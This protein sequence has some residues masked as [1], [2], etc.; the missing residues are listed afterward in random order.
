MK[1]W[2]LYIVFCCAFAM[3]ACTIEN[4]ETDNIA[5]ETLDTHNYVLAVEEASNADITRF[6]SFELSE[7]AANTEP[8]DLLSENEIFTNADPSVS[9]GHQ[10]IGRYFFA[11]AKDKKGYSSTPGVYRLT[12]NRSNR[13]FI[14]ESLNLRKNS[15]FPSR[16][17]CI[18]N[19]DLG[20]YY[21]EGLAAHSI[22]IFNPYAMVT[23][24]VIDLQEAIQ[25]FRS[26][27][28]WVDESGNNRV[29]TGSMVIDEKEGKLYVSIVF[30]ETVGFNIIA[31]EDSDFYLAVIDIATKK[32]EKIISYPDTRTV[33][34]FVSE[35]NP[36]TKDDAGNLYF[37]SW[38]WNQFGTPTASKVFRIRS[39][40]RDFDTAWEFNIEDEFGKDHIA[41]SII[42]Y[43]GKIYLHIS[44]NAYTFDESDDLN[45]NIRMQYYELD[46]T[47]LSYRELDIPSSDPSSRMNVFSVVDDVL[48]VCVPNAKPGLFNGLYAIDKAG[49]T[50]EIMKIAN[51]YRPVRLYKLEDIE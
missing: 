51:K 14:D 34:F 50:S 21:N 11:M 17:L 30:L 49:N 24:G 43:N 42:G 47:D 36:T 3:A 4:L 18:V 26:D 9:A 35:N 19:R 22:Y 20:F 25:D 45:S 48:H 41:Q 29:R 33:G 44:A 46:P 5:R 38:G 7:V 31:D 32:V 40:E 6:F 12:L 23:T 27:I 28:A 8:Y 37:C 2:Y 39:G 13:V 1:H 16:K 10:A 15:L